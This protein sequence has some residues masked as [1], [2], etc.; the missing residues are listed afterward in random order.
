MSTSDHLALV[1]D[2]D[3]TLVP[4]STSLFLASRGFDVEA[5]WGKDV[6]RMVESGFDSPLAYLQ[7]MLDEVR[8]GRLQNLTLKELR[9]FGA[10]LDDKYFSGLPGLFEDLKSIV[11]E[12]RDVTLEC[13]II[14]SGLQDLI[15]GSQIVQ[16]HF[17]AAYGC[18]FE[19]NPDTGVIARIKRCVTFT[20]KTRYLFEINK[21]IE[22]RDSGKNPG[23]VNKAVTDRRI[24][25]ENMIYVGDGL[26]D[27]PCFSL[28]KQGGGLAFGVFDPLRKGSAR[29]A[30]EEFLN[31]GRTTSSHHPK[32]GPDDE[33]G[34]LLRTAVLSKASRLVISRQQA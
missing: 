31:A 18:R 21:G 1:F 27:I 30:L 15:E 10:S 16:K 24:P 11:A 3:D 6:K 19:E 29:L 8:D 13:Y 23:L 12:V 2:F 17:T 4:D 28:I 9:E 7:L 14:S 33:L 26:T 34:Q 32:Y 5:F 25:L 20:E 22:S